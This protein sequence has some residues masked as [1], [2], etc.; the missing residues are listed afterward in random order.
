MIDNEGLVFRI[1]HSDE[2]FGR[3]PLQRSSYLVGVEPCFT[4]ERVEHY[5]EIVRQRG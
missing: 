1:L 4:Y 3:K 2:A 5:P